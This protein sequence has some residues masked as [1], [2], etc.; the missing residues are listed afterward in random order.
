LGASDWRRHAT[1]VEQALGG[2]QAMDLYADALPAARALQER[3]YRTAIIANQPAS[4]RDQLMAMGVAPDGVAMSEAL[5]VSKPHDRFYRRALELLGGPDPARV[6]HVG[7]RVDN[8]VVP[9]RRNGLRSVWLRRGPWGRL[10]RDDTGAAELV[11]ER[12]AELPDRLL[13][14]P[15]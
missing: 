11:I 8:D 12:L 6:A 14:L 7:D 13:E 3:G 5:G 1:A 9:A 2:L 4:R 10:Q 15:G